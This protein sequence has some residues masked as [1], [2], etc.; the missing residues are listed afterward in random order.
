MLV[1]VIVMHKQFFIS[2]VAAIIL[3]SLLGGY[4]FHQYKMEDAEVFYEKN[5]I[6]FFTEGVYDNKERAQKAT[7]DIETKV[8]VKEDAKYYVYLAI[9]KNKENKERLMKMYQDKKIEVS[10]KEMSITN[11]SFL[12]CLQQMDGLIPSV[13]TNEELETINKV[14]LANYE[15][16]ILKQ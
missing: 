9:T 12:T 5:A 4:L 15:E 13:K 16:L 6:Y 7:E 14:V 3:G 10:I 8:I 11:T 2:L 1:M